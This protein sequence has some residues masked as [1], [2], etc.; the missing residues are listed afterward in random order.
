MLLTNRLEKAYVV[1]ILR[2]AITPHL[3]MACILNLHLY[4]LKSWIT[5]IVYSRIFAHL[6]SHSIRA[7]GTTMEVV[8]L[9]Y[10]QKCEF[11]RIINK[12]NPIYTLQ[13]QPIK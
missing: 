10:L 6:S 2:R 11:L 9:I 7:V 13:N 3:V 4:A 5:Y 1:P 8:F 12:R